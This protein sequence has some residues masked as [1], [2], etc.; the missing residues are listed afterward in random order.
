MEDRALRSLLFA[1]R[2]GDRA[3]FTALYDAMSPPLYTVLFRIVGDRA[4][5]EDLL[6]E[7]FLRVYQ[8]P[9]DTARRPRAYL[10]AM[11]RNL[12]LDDL[13]RRRPE[14]AL[15]EL[16]AAPAVDVDGRVD[17]ERALSALSAADRQLVTLHLNAGLKFREIAQVMEMP[18]GTVLWRYRRAIELLR[19]ELEGSL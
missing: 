18:L 14:A 15:S 12:A 4:A 5:A 11:A 10:F 2:Q 3:A 7:L 16:E 17:V 8:S 6:Q 1:V 9:P 13:R 19:Q